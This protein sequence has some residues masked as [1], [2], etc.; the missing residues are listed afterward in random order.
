[1]TKKFCDICG[2]E[3]TMFE[4]ISVYNVAITSKDRMHRAP[5]TRN[6]PEVC[7]DCADRIAGIIDALKEETNG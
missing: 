2:K 1:M 3:L 7:K 6:Y 5:H 4:Q